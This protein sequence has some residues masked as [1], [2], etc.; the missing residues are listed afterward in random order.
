MVDPLRQ[1]GAEL[2]SLDRAV[3]KIKALHVNVKDTKENVR[4]TI[5]RYFNE[6]RPGLVNSV[7]DDSVLTRLD[8]EMHELLRCTQQRTSVKDY[9]DLLRRAHEALSELELRLIR[10]KPQASAPP[11]HNRQHQQIL[12]MLEG[13]CPSAGRSFRQGL[14]DF[15]DADRRSWRGTAVEFR[16]A[17]REVLD[18]LAPD[19]QVKAQPS[20]KQ[21]PN[22][23]GPTMKQ[24][25]VFVLKS[26]RPKD[27]QVKAFVEAIDVVENLI[28]KFVRAVY[29]RSALSVH[30][31]SS[32]D[33]VRRIRDYVSLVLVELLEVSL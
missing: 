2:E 9:R 16:E 27:P 12:E 24:K 30:T 3:R 23:D 33:D 21:E 14:N 5:Y 25:A 13:V 7:G 11:T 22:I 31:P 15:S 29:T 20:Y 19:E 32:R 18:Q 26:R 1:L 6:R 17:L 10:P 4:A 8:S 28:G